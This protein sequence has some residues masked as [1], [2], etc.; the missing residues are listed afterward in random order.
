MDAKI[1]MKA[2][3]VIRDK[4]AYRKYMVVE[5]ASDSNPSKKYRVDLTNGR[6]SCP[7]WIFQRARAEDRKPCKHLVRL[8]YKKAA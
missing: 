5:V 8:G 6:C 7:S 3:L 4:G 1:A 2:E